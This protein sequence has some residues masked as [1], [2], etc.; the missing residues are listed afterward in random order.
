MQLHTAVGNLQSKNVRVDGTR[1][2]MRL[3]P[4]LWDALQDI[5]RWE[6]TSIEDQVCRAVS[7]ATLNQSRTSA[8][9]A[10]IVGYFRTLVAENTVIVI[11]DK[12]L[13]E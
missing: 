12:K 9:R 3:E 8:V 11:M 1:T 7:A 4:L 13:R 6:K 5:A 2:S 10:Y